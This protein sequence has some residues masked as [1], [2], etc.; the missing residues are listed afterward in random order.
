[1]SIDWFVK[2]AITTVALFVKTESQTPIFLMN[3]LIYHS[4]Y[5]Y[6]ASSQRRGLRAVY[7][8]KT[9]KAKKF[10]IFGDAEKVKRDLERAGEPSYRLSIK[11]T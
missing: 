3:F 6:L 2:N 1:M 7:V 9:E 10:S 4:S 5:G 8:P 11:E